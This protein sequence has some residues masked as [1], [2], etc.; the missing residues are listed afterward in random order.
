MNPRRRT[1][2]WK[3]ALGENGF[4]WVEQRDH[5]CVAIGWDETGNL[6][7]YKTPEAIKRRFYRIR[8][9]FKTKPYQ[10]IKFY[11]DVNPNDKILASYGKH[12]FGLGT[13]TGNYK[14]DEE[15]YYRHSKPVRWELKF[16]EPL[17]AEELDLPEE[18]VKKIRRRTILELERKEWEVIEKAVSQMR[19]PFEGL[20]NFEGLCR[21]P[22][23][24]QEVIILFSKLSQHLKMKIESVSTR[25]PDA[26]I[27]IKKGK[28][29]TTKAAEFELYSS[30]FESHMRDYRKDPDSCDMIICWKDN[31]KQKPSDLEVVELRKELEQ[32]V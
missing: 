23:T 14:F 7:K 10:L 11:K 26:Y 12:I 22:Q 8:W 3:I 27:R 16:W 31:W 19:N 25:Y 9:G 18:L 6:N 17:N 4:L 24:E 13:V 29:W 30:D 5:G 15:L 28:G 1:R 21:A 2:Y 20:T 32:I